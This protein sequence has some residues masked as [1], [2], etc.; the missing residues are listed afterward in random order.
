[1]RLFNQKK[2]WHGVLKIDACKLLNTKSFYL[3]LTLFFWSAYSN[4]PLK[5]CT[6]AN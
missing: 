5:S 2:T 3:G 6:E 1:M 4:S